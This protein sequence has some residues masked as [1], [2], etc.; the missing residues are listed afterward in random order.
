MRMDWM[1]EWMWVQREAFKLS[2]SIHNAVLSSSS[3]LPRPTFVIFAA[4]RAASKFSHHLFIY[5]LCLFFFF[6]KT[7]WL[8]QLQQLRQQQKNG[9]NRQMLVHTLQIE[10]VQCNFALMHIVYTLWDMESWRLCPACMR[11]YLSLCVC[12]YVCV[13]NVC[14]LLL[15]KYESRS[16]VFLTKNDHRLLSI[17]DTAHNRATAIQATEAKKKCIYALLLQQSSIY[18]HSN[19]QTVL[20]H[21]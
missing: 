12:V 15:I 6:T 7:P 18:I 3:S 14:S 9:L 8:E 11:S 19:G 10:C 21:Q 1:H 4:H 20:L 13:R 2:G 5:H 17:L 16:C